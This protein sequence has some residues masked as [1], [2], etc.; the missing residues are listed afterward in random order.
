MWL[1]SRLARSGVG[2]NAQ[3]WARVSVLVDAL[4]VRASTVVVLVQ[5]RP[6][7]SQVPRAIANRVWRS[8][9]IRKISVTRVQPRYACRETP[10]PC[11]LFD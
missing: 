3:A 7:V 4:G 11:F 6:W 1:R 9:F 2:S 10:R 5:D 8:R